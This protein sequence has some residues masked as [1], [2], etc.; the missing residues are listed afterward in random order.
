MTPVDS[1][2][3]FCRDL[4]NRTHRV[5]RLFG[6]PLMVAV[7]LPILL[8]VVAGA[9][10]L[11]FVAFP[12]ACVLLYWSFR[13]RRT[14]RAFV[15]NTLTDATWG[16]EERAGTIGESW[17]LGNA[18]EL[19]A[20]FA[21]ERRAQEEIFPERTIDQDKPEDSNP[22][23]VDRRIVSPSAFHSRDLV[24]AFS[25]GVLLLEARHT[26]EVLRSPFEECD[27]FVSCVTRLWILP[28]LEFGGVILYA[29]FLI[30]A[31][32]G[33]AWA[34][35]ALANRWIKRMRERGAIFHKG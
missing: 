13:A 20:R 1:Q 28:D 32:V 25:A 27:T 9:P 7:F 35:S 18:L 15:A 23:S 12:V 11:L 16:D 3:L 10:V 14:P 34:V 33:L 31:V 24:G 29:G 21:I 2:F 5:A 30:A 4:F 6:F 17:L 26:L 8:V 19:S 22:I